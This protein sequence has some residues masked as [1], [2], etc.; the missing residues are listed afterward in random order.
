M[1][2]PSEALLQLGLYDY[3]WGNP[4]LLQ[5]YNANVQAAKAREEQQAYNMLWKQIEEKKAADERAKADAAAAIEKAKAE[6]LAA[7]EKAK[8]EEQARKEKETKLAGLYKDYNNAAGEQERAYIAKQIN[9]LEGNT[10]VENEMIA[11]FDADRAAKQKADRDEALRHSA[12]LREIADIEAQS[13]KLK[14]ANQKDALANSVYDTSK[15]PNMNDAERDKLY[16]SLKGIKALDEKVSDAVQGAQASHAGK[17][18]A[19]NLELQDKKKKLAESGRK[20]IA[21]G[22]P[23]RVTIAE[24]TAMNEG[25]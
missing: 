15:Y 20:K 14:K 13:R 16:A 3:V 23:G 25:Y 17:K 2:D 11:A 1:Y 6:A 8:A 4:G 5:T 12:A 7:A 24:Q 22:Q 18:T 21:N 19:E 9:A 10:S